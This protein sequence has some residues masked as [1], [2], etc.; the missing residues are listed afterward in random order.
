MKLIN[1]AGCVLVLLTF[2]LRTAS[3]D[4]TAYLEG[5]TLTDG[6]QGTGATGVVGFNFTVNSAISVTQ[7]GFFGDALGGA[8]TPWVALY[9][10]TTST[11]LAAITTYVSTNGWQYIA[12][13]TPV[14]LTAGD[15]YQ[16]AATAYWSPKYAD[17]S[18]FTFGPEI[19]PVS[20]SS[21]TG[22]GGWGTP[23]MGTGVA[24]TANV[25]GNFLY[26]SAVI[27]EP[28]ACVML[29]GLAALGC[30]LLRRRRRR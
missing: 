14:T 5:G 11:Q 23:T 20:F 4:T 1:C 16:V 13:D 17:T 10:V 8:D 26:T 3:A 22:W 19:N 25:T 30:G 6:T 7:L 28:S 9:D 21:P 2:G 29:A 24:A 12:L 18:G 15:T 27:P